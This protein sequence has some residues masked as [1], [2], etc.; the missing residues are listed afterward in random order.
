MTAGT[1]VRTRR[2][3]SPSLLDGLSIGFYS[4]A[5]SWG[6]S[7]VYQ[8]QVMAAVTARGSDAVRLPGLRGER[9]GGQSGPG[10]DAAAQGP[11]TRNAPRAA[12]GTAAARR[13]VGLAREALRLGRAWRKLRPAL[14]HVNISGS[15]AGL[16]A[17]RLS[18]ARAVVG[19][20]HA[21]PESDTGSLGM[22]C[23]L[24]EWTGARCMDAAIAVSE[25]AKRQWI[26]RVRID[27][28]RVSVIYNGVDPGAFRPGRS[29]SA[30]R[31]Q[32]GLPEGAVVLGTNAR[33]HP[34]KGLAHLL[35]AAPQIL[36]ARPQAHFVIAGDGPIRAELESMARR[37]RLGGQVRF[38]GFRDDIADL[39]QIYDLFLLPSLQ[40]AVPFALL[41]AMSLGRAV[42]ATECG[43][44]PEVVL[45][46][47][48][49]SIVPPRDSRALARAVID[50]LA[51]DAKRRAFGEA[52][53]A[54]VAEHYTPDR[55]LARTLDVIERTY[56]RKAAGAR[57]GH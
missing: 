40:E 25:D 26:A 2:H 24:L 14:V 3:R 13:A 37:L 1:R 53:R 29:A 20:F 28:R 30:V 52:A 9:Q 34:I 12:F 41:E 47:V 16:P 6:G 44:V 5:R 11:V 56:A 51:D 4:D 8:A 57:H 54:R 7:E 31:A 22:A 21:N 17:A 32:L 19:T 39:T 18:G 46:G 45:D 48:T 55:M 36:A 38:L 35:T 10:G 15:E 50:L 23:R 42:V 33:L 27:P 43:G 49:G